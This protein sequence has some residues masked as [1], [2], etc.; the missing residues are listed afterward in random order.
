MI[1]N[2][3][4]EPA[5]VSIIKDYYCFDHVLYCLKAL[6][7]WLKYSFKLCVCLSLKCILRS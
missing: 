3:F 6:Q 2:T 7:T 5:N 1:Y 4:T